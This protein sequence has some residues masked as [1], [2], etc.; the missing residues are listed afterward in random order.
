MRIKSTKELCFLEIFFFHFLIHFSLRWVNKL[1]W[2]KAIKFN[3]ELQNPTLF[4][5]I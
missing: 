1:F 3:T 5:E 2:L 4:R